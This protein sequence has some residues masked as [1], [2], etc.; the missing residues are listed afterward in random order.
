MSFT[1]TAAIALSAAVSVLIAP[2]FVSAQDVG[3]AQTKPNI[4]VIFGDDVGTW[5]VSAYHRGMMGGSTPSIDRLAAEG[6][7]FTDYYAQQ[8]C[9]AGRAAFILGQSPYRTGLLTIGMPGAKQGI[10]PKDPTLA[11][12][13]ENHGYMSGQFGKNHLGD[14][15]EH[16]PTNHGFDEFYG[17]LYHLNAE[18]EPET[19]FY[20]KNPEFHEQFGPRGV[21]R[22]Y[23][24]GRIEDTGPLTRKRMETIEEDLT[25]STIDFMERAHEAGK[26]FFIWHNSTRMHV[27]TR[28]SEKW[29]GKTGYGLYADGMAELDDNVGQLLAKLDELAI[30]DN[31]IVIF[32]TDNGAELVTWPDGGTIP[33]RGEKGTT[34]EGG[35]R[36]PA[37]V[38]WPGLVKPGSVINGIF[39]MEDWIPTLIAAVGNPNIKEDLKKGH[40]A[41]GKRFKVH[42]D[43]YDQRELLAG[44]GPSNRHEI[45]YFDAGGNLNAIRYDDWKLNFT[46]MEGDIT[47]AYRKTPSWPVVYNLRMS[48]FE[49]PYF[50]SKMYVRWMADQMWLF[51]PAQQVLG[52]FLATFME[53]PQRQP[54]GSLSVDQVMNQLS[55]G[56]KD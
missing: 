19:E 26:P 39:S 49:R 14:Q 45:F 38:R 9:T 20:P 13:L 43:G 32:T 36:V 4:L 3:A 10:S 11:D 5:N 22:S 24:D 46:I 23:A 29:K 35:F 18:E 37:L 30:A 17:N 56:R 53:F 50:E 51:V 34:W 31:T 16:L 2:S 28:L 27:W 41:N 54:I 25:D 21:I 7:V 40:S 47:E 48:P 52:R 1:R 12:L 33:F 44:R 15:D 42:L 8:S 55:E 6:A